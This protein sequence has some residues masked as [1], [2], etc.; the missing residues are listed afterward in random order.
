MEDWGSKTCDIK[1]VTMIKAIPMQIKDVII[2]D[3]TLRNKVECL[4]EA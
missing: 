1:Q 3:Q 2:N 4:P